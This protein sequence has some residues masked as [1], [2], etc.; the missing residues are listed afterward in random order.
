MRLYLDTEWQNE[1]ARELVSL[2]LVSQDGRHRF[3]A[4][5]DPLPTAPS[6]FVRDVVYP[7]LER[8]SVA[9]PDPEFSSRLAA[10]LSRVRTALVVADSH[11]DFELLS[12]ALA[13]FGQPSLRRAPPYRTIVATFGDVLMRVEN[14]FEDHPN[15]KARRH[16]AL[17]DAEA[18]RWAFEGKIGFGGHGL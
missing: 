4:E 17:V 15:D 1:I 7:L 6:D 18:L 14:Y 5:R 12:H 11:V 10:F 16:H 9:L 8:G 2:A 3:Y 13:G